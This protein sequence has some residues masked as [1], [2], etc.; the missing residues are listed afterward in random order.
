MA[1]VAPN[2]S[3]E[4]VLDTAALLSLYLADEPLPPSLEP[5]IQR[6]CIGDALL[7]LTD[8]CLL[9]CASALLKQM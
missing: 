6:S 5:A 4:F 3:D 2:R 7:L 9:R 8:I 1:E